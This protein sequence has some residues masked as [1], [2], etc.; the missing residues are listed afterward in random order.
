[1]T[2]QADFKRRVR[3]RM[4]KTG[5]SYAAAR[6]RLLAERPPTADVLHVTNGDSTVAGLRPLVGEALPWRDVL[7]EGPVP[8]TDDEEL[9]RV[10]AAFLGMERAL[11]ELAARDAALAAN[12]D[13]RYVL[14]FEADLYDQLQLAQIL[15]RLA[16]LAV[17]PERITLICIGEHPGIAHFGGLGELAPEQLVALRDSAAATPLTPAAFALGRA[18]WDALRAPAPDGFGAIAGARCPELRFL[19]EAFDRLGREYPSTR[20]GLGL[21]ERRILALLA[22]EPRS[23]GALFG[24]LGAREARPYLGDTSAFAAM[25]RLA[26]APRPLLAANPLPVGAATRLELTADG[27][28]VLQGAAD[29][30]ELNGL[31]RWIGGVHLQG[32]AVDWRWDDARERI[33][34]ARR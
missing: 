6:A 13:G 33:V 4:V 9:R 3:A 31:D 22:E 29:H 24:A 5:E 34:R 11:P 15:A 26:R 27:E 10:R 19:P 8:A 14:W 21:T 7:H 23:A 20:D 25:E 18:A 32:R 16:A 28:R 30:V 2:R 1:M 12:R 17:A